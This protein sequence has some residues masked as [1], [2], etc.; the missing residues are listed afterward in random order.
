MERAHSS[1][2]VLSSI[3][4]IADSP[5]CSARCPS[6]VMLHGFSGAGG[7]IAAAGLP[8]EYKRVTLANSP[9]KDAQA[10]GG[11]AGPYAV[12]D[13]VRQYTSTFTRQFADVAE[14]TGQSRIKSLY[15][16]SDSPGTGKTTTAAAILNEYIA[17][18]YVGSLRRGLPVSERPAYF[19]DVNAWQ[20]DY[21]EFNRPRVPEHIAEPASARYYSAQKAAMSA[22]FAVLD[23]MGVRDCTEAFR[24]DLHRV[25]NA[26]VSGGLPTVYTSNV[27]LTQLN[28]VFREQPARLA[29]RVRDMC[30]EIIF[31]G[32]SR[33]GMR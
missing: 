25:I 30:A 7:R 17:V 14:E 24:A 11:A 2:C 26:R 10:N 27:G 13:M 18:H 21:N 12:Y 31:S 29:D 9:A 16:V 33:R 19:L 22:P 3:C 23:D 6:Y 15:L 4:T 8:D 1:K 5:S 20:S 32:E 28:E